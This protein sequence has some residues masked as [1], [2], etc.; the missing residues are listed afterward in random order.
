MEEN[1]A[2]VPRHRGIGRVDEE[3]MQVVE[4]PSEFVGALRDS[5]PRYTKKPSGTIVEV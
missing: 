3:F 5:N 4:D 1:L 2:H